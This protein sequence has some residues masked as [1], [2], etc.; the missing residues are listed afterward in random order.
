[1]GFTDLFKP[2]YKHS[3]YSVRKK[4][5]KKITDEKL[6][7][8]IAKNDPS[9]LVRGEAV[10]KIKNQTTL[11][12]I[13]KMESYSFV[14]F[15]AFR[16]IE[17]REEYLKTI[18]D[19]ALLCEIAKE[20]ENENI[21]SQA[22]KQISDVYYLKEIATY[23]KKFDLKDEKISLEAVKKITD[24]ETLQDIINIKR[25]WGS[26]KSE[27]R[28]TLI[29][30]TNDKE[31]LFTFLQD[32][33]SSV[34]NRLAALEKITDK[35]LL[36]KNLRK[37]DQN[38][39]PHCHTNERLYSNTGVITAHNVPYRKY[40][41]NPNW[42]CGKCEKYIPPDQ[43]IK[44]KPEIYE[45][46][47]ER[48]KELGYKIPDYYENRYDKIAK[49]SNQKELN[50]IVLDKNLPINERKIALEKI[51]DQVI[52]GL[53]A[54]DSYNNNEELFLMAKNKITDEKVL[55][56]VKRTIKKIKKIKK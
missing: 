8:E 12:E 44:D 38:L 18:N 52:L 48:M 32:T 25:T 3:D 31:I 14:K 46:T 43:I 47:A 1:M 49:I 5:V 37:Y 13:I 42:R 56:D 36:E 33:R 20:D 16:N 6:L 7:I 54:I 9:N 55:A 30:I 26:V 35:E 21:R 19:E 23:F 27:A 39:C 4:A 11:K 22:V 24:P 10:K 2:K 53:V 34:D 50:G 28:K 17:N 41:D 45:K 29:E 51:T 15:Y 40:I